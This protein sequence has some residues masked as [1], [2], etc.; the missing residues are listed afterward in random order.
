MDENRSAIVTGGAG[1]IGLAT[2]ARLLKRGMSVLLVDSN[3]QEARK[4]EQHFASDRLAVCIADVMDPQAVAD[5]TE[6]A[7]TRF[8]RVDALVNVA[9]GAGAVKAYEIENVSL[10][11]WDLVMAL[12]VRSTFL[13]CKAVIPHMRRQ[14]YGRIINLSSILA[15]GE[16]GPPTTVAARLPYATAKA[17]L[18]GFTSQLAKD[19]ASDG[20]TVNALLPGL[21]LGEEGTRIRSRFEA[22]DDAVKT[23]MVAGYPVGRPGEADEV[24][25]AIEFLT[26]EAAGYIT[27]T[28]LPIDGGYLN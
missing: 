27:G 6:E 4:A 17:A 14:R 3:A 13:F 11:T 23:G 9:G 26:S 21:I 22:L 12:N 19:V 8:N 2:V 15:R 7:H 24:A 5:A 16:K 28:A 10:D 25:A 18:L 1:G 20:I